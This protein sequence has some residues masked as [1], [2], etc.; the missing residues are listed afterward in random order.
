MKVLHLLSSS[1]YSGAEN[2]VCQI[3]NILEDKKE[4]KL[5]YCSPD[6]K[7]REAIKDKNI[8]FEPLQKMTIK[9]IKRVIEKIKPDIIHAHDMRASFLAALLCKKI[10]LISHIHNNNFNSRRFSLKSILYYFA[11]KKAKN[12]IWVSKAAYEGYVFHKKLRNKSIILYNIINPKKLEEKIKEDCNEYA[13]DVIYLGRLSMEKDPRRLLEVLKGLLLKRPETKIAIVGD[14]EFKNEI[15]CLLKNDDKLSNINYLGFKSNPYKMLKYAKVM[16][17]TSRTEGTP[18]CVLESLYL[19]TPVVSTPVGGIKYLI[20]NGINGYLANTN[21][22][23]IDKIYEILQ[24][25]TKY[26]S[27]SKNCIRKI[28]NDMNTDYYKNEILNI[29]KLSLSEKNK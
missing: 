11:A 22:E 10:P 28:N 2:V 4:I 9:E 26:Q 6:G 7:I 29:Y 13:Y 19:G 24:D 3:K 5:I 21:D 20:E 27:L 16:V 14:G 15:I 12:I 25:D 17:M 8:Q 18:M 23:L 1:S